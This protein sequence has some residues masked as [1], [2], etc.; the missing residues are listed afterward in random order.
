[1]SSERFC[2][3]SGSHFSFSIASGNYYFTFC[4]YEFDYPMHSYRNYI[5]FS[6]VSNF[7][8]FSKTFSR[9][10]YIVAHIQILPFN[11]WVVFHNICI[12]HLNKHGWMCS[13]HCEYG[14]ITVALDRPFRRSLK[15]GFLSQRLL[16]DQSLYPAWLQ[17]S[18]HFD[19]LAGFGWWR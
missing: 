6:F 18:E 19:P 3:E 8:L 5:T 14:Y 9:L 10:I 12:A 17:A 2:S 13:G 15:K 4:A 7:F 1:M 16:S 11:G